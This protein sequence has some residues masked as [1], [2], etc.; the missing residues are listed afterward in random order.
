[1][2]EHVVNKYVRYVLYLRSAKLTLC[3][4]MR[5]W[6]TEILNKPILKHFQ[7]LLHF[8]KTMNYERESIYLKIE[9]YV[10]ETHIENAI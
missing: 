9:V 3:V 4:K 7:I 1:M 2:C 5:N 8:N 10:K 6:Q